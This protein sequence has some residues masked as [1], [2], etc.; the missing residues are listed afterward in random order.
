MESTA[1]TE[2]RGNETASSLRD[3][4]AS[5]GITELMEILKKLKEDRIGGNK[6]QFYGSYKSWDSLDEAQ[7]NK[8]TAWFALL[9]L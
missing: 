3:L 5:C 2:V 6:K 1:A 7:K 4:P 9:D 8:A